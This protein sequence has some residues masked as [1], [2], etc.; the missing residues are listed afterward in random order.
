[1]GGAH[2]V[3]YWTPES[4]V[5]MWTA[6]VFGMEIV[7][8]RFQLSKQWSLLEFCQIRSL[9][10]AVLNACVS[11]MVLELG[12]Q[13]QSR[14]GLEGNLFVGSTLV[15]WYAKLSPSLVPPVPAYGQL[16]SLDAFPWTALIARLLLA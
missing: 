10:V 3:L 16:R 6:M 13:I 14:I 7:K 2:N 15:D 8:R 11:P 5:M 9:F 1:M 4:D 12:M